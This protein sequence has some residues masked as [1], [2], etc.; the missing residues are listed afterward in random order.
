MKV[1]EEVLPSMPKG[2]TVGNIVI[3][4]KGA[5][6]SSTRIIIKD[7]GADQDQLEYKGEIRKIRQNYYAGA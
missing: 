1:L 5:E 7:K 2:E 3:Y 4:G 6:R